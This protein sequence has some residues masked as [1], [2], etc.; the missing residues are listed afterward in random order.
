MLIVQTGQQTEFGRI[1]RRLADVEAETDFSRGIRE[2]GYLLTR[3]MFFVVMFVVVV[4]LLL[5]RPPLESLL[6]AVALAVGLTP[7]LLPAIVS[8]TLSVGIDG[9]QSQG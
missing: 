3:I 5:H 8:V 7:E 2:F 6:F 9:W 4:N 1:A